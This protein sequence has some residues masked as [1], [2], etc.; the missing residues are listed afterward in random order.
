MSEVTLPR[1]RLT[2]APTGQSAISLT[3]V[4][5]NNESTD[6]LKLRVEWKPPE[7]AHGYSHG[8]RPTSAVPLACSADVQVRL[9]RAA[10]QTELW[11]AQAVSIYF[12]E[13]KSWTKKLTVPFVSDDAGY[14][15]SAGKLSARR[16]Y[17]ASNRGRAG[18]SLIQ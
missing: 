5:E 12:F 2:D 13:P 10:D 6:K 18:T 4:S 7:M 8:C 17:S 9:V 15:R 16:F 3:H 14:G 11:S 1:S